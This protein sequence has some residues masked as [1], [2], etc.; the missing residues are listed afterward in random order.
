LPV[1][2]TTFASVRT[3]ISAFLRSGSFDSRSFTCLVIWLSLSSL[4]SPT[5]YVYEIRCKIYLIRMLP[6]V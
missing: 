5:T 1:S 2:V 4:S 3:L 6:I